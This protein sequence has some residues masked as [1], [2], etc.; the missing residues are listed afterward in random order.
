MT[1]NHATAT[2]KPC[3]DRKVAAIR[4]ACS[5]RGLR[6]ILFLLLLSIKELFVSFKELISFHYESCAFQ[7]HSWHYLTEKTVLKN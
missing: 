5:R 3:Q 4:D 7:A 2:P 1:W 6:V